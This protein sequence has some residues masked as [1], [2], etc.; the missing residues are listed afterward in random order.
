M[1][2]W[3]LCAMLLSGGM[4]G[5][6]T[7]VDVAGDGKR[8]NLLV[9]C[10]RVVSLEYTYVEDKDRVSE[11]FLPF[12]HRVDLNSSFATLKVQLQASNVKC[13]SSN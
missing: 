5:M 7:A 4:E 1:W 6:V 2:G 8:Q 12:F 9:Q 13:G 10:T 3:L 11:S